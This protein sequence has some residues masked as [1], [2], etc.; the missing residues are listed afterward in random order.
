MNPWGMTDS[1]PGT[2]NMQDGP[3]TS[4]NGSCLIACE[5]Y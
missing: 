2:E 4:C 3:W 1:R 5:G